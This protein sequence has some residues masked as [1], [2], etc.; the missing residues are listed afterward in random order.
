MKNFG[1]TGTE[2][3]SKTTRV[4][5]AVISRLCSNRSVPA[6]L[7][8]DFCTACFLGG[9][10]SIQLS[11]EDLYKI[12]DFGSIFELTADMSFPAGRWFAITLGGMCSILLN[13][14]NIFYYIPDY[15]LTGCHPAYREAR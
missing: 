8:P 2:P 10:R 11:Y 14:R 4:K 3:F 15:N 9:A 5:P 6:L 13:S 1:F 12:D 7:N